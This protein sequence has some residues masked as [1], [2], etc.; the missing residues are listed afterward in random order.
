MSLIVSQDDALLDQLTRD[1]FNQKIQKQR[2]FEKKISW[3]IQDF[4]SNPIALRQRLI[5]ET[6]FQITGNLLGFTANHIRKIVRLFESPKVGKTLHMPSNIT[7]TCN[8]DTILFKQENKDNQ[9]HS[10]LKSLL[11]HQ[12]SPQ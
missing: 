12:Q 5:R 7:V 1:I 4:L 3:N 10:Y 9:Y 6:F 2:S 8:Y 11:H